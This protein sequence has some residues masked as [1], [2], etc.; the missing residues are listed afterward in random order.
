MPK[1]A[2]KKPMSKAATAAL[3]AL[4]NMVIS[5]AAVHIDP[6]MQEKLKAAGISVD[7]GRIDYVGRAIWE[8]PSGDHRVQVTVGQGSFASDWPDWAFGV[9]EGALH[10]NKKV[11]LAYNDRPLGSNLLEVDCMR[12]PVFAP[13]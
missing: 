5:D 11:L 10:F 3:K 6:V 12:L 9:A 1:T 4:Q 2:K 13:F 8:D 7:I